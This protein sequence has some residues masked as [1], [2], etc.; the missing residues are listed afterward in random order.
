VVVVVDLGTRP[1]TVELDEPEDCRRF[2]LLV[3]GS[4]DDGHLAAALEHAGAGR[5]ADH[6]TAFVSVDAVRGLAP[7]RVPD[8]WD[9]DFAAMLEFAGMKGWLA[10][11]GATIQAHVERDSP[12]PR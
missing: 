6:D 4:G 12:G 5:L 3:R 11:G 1:A 10:D 9:A 7:G 2:H 8:G